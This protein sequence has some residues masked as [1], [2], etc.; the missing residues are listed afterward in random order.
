V[1]TFF[2]LL[3]RP[4]VY[5]LVADILCEVWRWGWSIESDEPSGY[6]HSTMIVFRALLTPVSDIKQAQPLRI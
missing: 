3:F 6:G 1:T 4:T 2:E 5:T